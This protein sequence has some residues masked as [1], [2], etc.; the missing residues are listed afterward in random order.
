MLCATTALQSHQEEEELGGAKS[1]EKQIVQRAADTSQCLGR[2]APRCTSLQQSQCWTQSSAQLQVSLESHPPSLS[3]YW[4]GRKGEKGESKR[5]FSAF[6][7]PTWL[8]LLSQEI[9]PLYAL[10]TRFL[11]ILDSLHMKSI[12]RYG[13]MYMW[14]C[15]LSAHCIAQP[16]S[17]RLFFFMRAR[18]FSRP[19]GF[20]GWWC[21]KKIKNKKNKPSS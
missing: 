18:K 10:Q 7:F 3:H 15:Q 12:P 16:G 13:S 11:L 9:N 2:S 19:A 4:S 17:K 5:W 8:R 1:P 21:S 6:Y 20:S 14:S